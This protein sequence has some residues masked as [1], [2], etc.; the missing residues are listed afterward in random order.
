M[1]SGGSDSGSRVDAADFGSLGWPLPIE[2][3]VRGLPHGEMTGLAAVSLRTR[4]GVAVFLGG[5]DRGYPA[6]FVGA[7]GDLRGFVSRRLAG[8]GPR[9]DL[10]VV[11]DL[12]LA[13][14]VGSGFEADLAQWVLSSRLTPD[15]RGA[16]A[17][18]VWALG[19]DPEADVP[20]TRVLEMNE[21]AGLDPATVIGPFGRRSAAEAF[22]RLLDDRFELCRE[23]GLLARRPGATACA[24]KEMGKC[25]APCDGSEPMG[26]YRARAR[27][28]LLFAGRPIA[29]VSRSVRDSMSEATA[30]LDFE[31]AGSL[32]AELAGLKSVGGPAFAWVNTFDRFGV[33]AV[34]PS[35]R[36][37]WARLIVHRGGWTRHVFD[38]DARRAESALDES[39]D[40]FSPGNPGSPA[41]IAEG[42]AGAVGLLCR[43][44]FSTRRTRST[45]L[46][47]DP[48]PSRSDVLRAVRRAAKVE[49][50]GEGISGSRLEE[51]DDGRTG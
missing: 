48:P 19:L 45:F 18:A 9:A 13:C 4:P 17:G 27:A 26:A 37:G 22:G 49:A 11:T 44:L 51:M 29:D 46:R 38:V 43:H 42:S 6:F 1:S 10:G 14:E 31:T 40:R 34:L 16:P 24:Y 36:G 33:L 5:H 23:P 20:A 41:G 25:P 3:D 8:E 50:D 12:V 47:L 2:I 35:G 28:A 15:A 32:K 21:M 30:A 7:T 39:W